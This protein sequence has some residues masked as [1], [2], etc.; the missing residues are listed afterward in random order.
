MFVS[1]II[2]GKEGDSYHE[3]YDDKKGV[4][5]YK[6]LRFADTIDRE[7]LMTI[8]QAIKEGCEKVNLDEW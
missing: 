6:L 3:E 4:P 8:E 5:G 1:G 7:D 2:R